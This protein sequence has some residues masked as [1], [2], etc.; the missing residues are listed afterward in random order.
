MDVSRPI[1]REYADTAPFFRSAA[2]G[3]LRLRA[4]RDCGR[5][6]HLP[7]ERCLTCGSTNLEWR[8][9]SGI[10]RL[11]SWTIVRHQVHPAFPVPYCVVLVEL[12]DAP[13]V[14]L[15]GYLPGEHDFTPDEPMS[16]RFEQVADN[17]GLPQFTPAGRASSNDP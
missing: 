4:C 10:G 14:R 6:L 15:P 3:E 16:V 2:I 12:D 1:P 8:Q 13:G 17:S 11:Y 9:V 7:R 5:F